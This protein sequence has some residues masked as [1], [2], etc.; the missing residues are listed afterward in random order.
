MNFTKTTLIAFIA[1]ISVVLCSMGLYLF[2]DNTFGDKIGVFILR[3]IIMIFFIGFAFP[4]YYTLIVKK[5]S[6]STL[7]LTKNRIVI[8]LILNF[9]LAALLLLQ[10]INE[11]NVPWKEILLN[12]KAVI[13]IMYIFMAGIFEIV[14]FYGFLFYCFE[15][16]FGIIPG[17]LLTAIFYSFH[18]A[19]FQPEFFKLFFVGVM[20]ASVFRITRNVLIVFPFFWGVGATWDVLVNFGAQESLDGAF[21]LVKTIS[22]LVLMVL[23]TTFLIISN[24]HKKIKRVSG[25]K[26][27]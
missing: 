15:D 19:G 2:P 22:I 7:G 5:N 16:A 24:G 20:Y 9:V 3:D 21:T 17:I 26:L 4:L 8:S 23:F 14:F 10:F 11:A 6:L 25:V 18:H 12:S 27:K 1:G 13:P